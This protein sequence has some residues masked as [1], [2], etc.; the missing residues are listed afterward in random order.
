MKTHRKF[1]EKLSLMI[2]LIV[3]LELARGRS[4]GCPR[5]RAELHSGRPLSRWTVVQIS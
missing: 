1:F 4:H 2:Q 5:C 3:Y